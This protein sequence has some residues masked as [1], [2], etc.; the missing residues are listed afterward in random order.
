MQQQKQAAIIAQQ[1]QACHQI[2]E[3]L[4]KHGWKMT[5]LPPNSGF[6]NLC[7]LQPGIFIADI[8]DPGCRGIALLEWYKKSNPTAT[9]YALCKGVNTPVMRLA[10]NRGVSGFFYFN[11][12]GKGLDEQCGMGRLLLHQH[13]SLSIPPCHS[14]VM[15]LSS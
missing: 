6:H 10:R 12:S 3:L 11:S 2:G 8:D 15:R 4:H 13:H 5:I 9:T 7:R 14:A 1:S